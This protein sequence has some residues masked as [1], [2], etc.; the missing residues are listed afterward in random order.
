MTAGKSSVLQRMEIA[1]PES[2]LKQYSPG[3]DLQHMHQIQG[4]VMWS[5]KECC[6]S[7]LSCGNHY[8][9]RQPALN[10]LLQAYMYTD[11]YTRRD[12]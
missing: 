6:V 7:G 12:M 11:F 8:G 9:S 2:F 5:I 10:G 1:L 4:A 3:H